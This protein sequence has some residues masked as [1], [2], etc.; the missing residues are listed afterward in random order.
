MTSHPIHSWPYRF[1]LPKVNPYA[2]PANGVASAALTTPPTK[3][4]IV[5]PS[6]TSKGGFP[7][8]KELG[9]NQ[10]WSWVDV[11]VMFV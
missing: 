4:R 9:V 6:S 2:M 1:A 7:G 8:S 3:K 10:G 11:F 5:S